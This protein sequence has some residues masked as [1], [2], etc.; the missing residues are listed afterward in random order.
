MSGRKYLTEACTDSHR[1][2]SQ[3]R[4]AV[5]EDAEDVL[6]MMRQSLDEPHLNMT[7]ETFRI[8]LDDE[9]AFL[10]RVS[11]S[12]SDAF[13]IA[14]E[15]ESVVGNIWVR[16]GFEDV[17]AHVA[18]VGVAVVPT[19]QGRGVGSR[20]I[21]AGLAWAR[22][23]KFVRIELSVD[24]ANVG[25]V[26]LYER[27]GFAVEGRHKAMFRRRGEFVDTLSMALLLD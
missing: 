24:E 17:R 9:R 2:R 13:L 21:E 14:L 15:G 8:T 12:Q 25:A 11:R 18:D 23:Q 4:R 16:G 6:A 27:F 1:C 22:E 20:L 5:P 3:I 10:E 19:H 7:R 26:R